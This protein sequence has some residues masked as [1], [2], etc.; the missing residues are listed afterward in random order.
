MHHEWP[1]RVHAVL[2]SN[3]LNEIAV[4]SASFASCHT[5]KTLVR[6]YMANQPTA[7]LAQAGTRCKKTLLDVWTVTL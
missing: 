6:P 4:D 1:V 3:F 2:K 7:Y 5:N